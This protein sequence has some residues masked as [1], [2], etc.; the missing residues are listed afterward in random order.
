MSKSVRVW[1]LIIATTGTFAIVSHVYVL[2]SLPSFMFDQAVKRIEARGAKFNTWSVAPRTTPDDQPVVR[3]SPDLSYSV[4]LL[5]LAEGPIR[6][7]APRWMN[8]GSLAVFQHD[9]DNVYVGNLN[10]TGDLEIVV[11]TEHQVIVQDIEVVRLPTNSG[12]AL[13]R[14]LAPD[15]NSFDV[16]AAL[17]VRSVC[18]VQQS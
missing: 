4:C 7:S 15:D 3:A 13:I 10:G 1:L 12:L 9:T 18:E 17:S 6:I 14:R 2:L 5:D 16:S 11:A 8:Y